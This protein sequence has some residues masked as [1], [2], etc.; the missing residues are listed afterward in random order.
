[1]VSESVICPRC[2]GELVVQWVMYNG[3]LI[4]QCDCGFIDVLAVVPDTV[5]PRFIRSEQAHE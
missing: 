4:G 3:G 5:D 1:M 2:G